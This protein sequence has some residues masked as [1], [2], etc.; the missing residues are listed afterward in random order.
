MKLAYVDTSVL[1]ALAFGDA[2]ARSLGD[3]LGD[4]AAYDC[5][6]SSNLLEAELRSAFSREG[7]P[8]ERRALG[9]VRWVLPE[10]PLTRE[11][12]AVLASGYLRGA[13]LWHVATALYVTPRPEDLAFVTLDARQAAVARALGFMTVPA[14]GGG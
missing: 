7:L 4:L 9:D 11:L 6:L 5:L 14:A 3:L 12:S 2:E 8:F 10:R 1:A 13:D